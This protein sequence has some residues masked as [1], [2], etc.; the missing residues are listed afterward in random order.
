MGDPAVRREHG[1]CSGHRHAHPR[2]RVTPGRDRARRRG[3]GR[4][5][6]GPAAHRANAR[7]P[8]GTAAGLSGCVAE[9]GPHIVERFVECQRAS[10][11]QAPA[12]MSDE[13]IAIRRPR[14]IATP[15]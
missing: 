11:L 5:G 7:H 8:F 14:L 6:A 3:A 10:F 2:R 12:L 13:T 15:A 1:S 4:R 9:Y